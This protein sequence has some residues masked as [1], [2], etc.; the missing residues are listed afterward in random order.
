MTSDQ[1]IIVGAGGHGRVVLDILRAGGKYAVAG[2]VDADPALAGTQVGGLPVFGHINVLPKLLQKKIRSAVVAIGDAAARES[3]AKVLVEHGFTLISAIHPSAVI[4]GGVTLGSNVVIA[5]GVVIGTETRVEDSAIINTGATV[6]HE[7][8]VGRA[9][10]ICPGVSLAGRVTVGPRA[11]VGIGAKVIQCLSIGEGAIVGAGCVVIRDVP[12][13]AT[14]V[15]VPAR[16][17]KT[18]QG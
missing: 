14:V 13:G 7:C 4:A 1:V 8:V 12:P 3:Y 15:G 11:F 6:D 9:C 10:H 18:N 5:A 17:V 16:V 2:F